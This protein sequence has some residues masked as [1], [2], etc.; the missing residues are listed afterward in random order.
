[1]KRFASLS[2]ALALAFAAPALAEERM[3]LAVGASTTLAFSEPVRRIDIDKAGVLEASLKDSEHVVVKALAPG[4]AQLSLGGGEHSELYVV[5]VDSP[6]TLDARALAE[7]LRA[8]PGLEE[9]AVEKKGDAFVLSGPVADLESHG[10]AVDLATALAGKPPVDMMQVEG[11]QMVAVDI[12]FFAV[13]SNTLRALGFNLASLNGDLQGAFTAPNTLQDFS[14]NAEGLSI[15][16]SPALQGAFNLLLANPKNGVMGIFSALSNAGLSRVLAQPTLLVRSGDQAEFLAGGDVPI[17]VPQANGGVGATVTIEYRPYGVRLAVAPVVMSDKRIVLKLTP[18]VSELDYANRIQVQGFSIPA[19]RR[20]SAS[21]TV[22]LGDGQ[23][24]VI[25]GLMY[26]SSN[27]NQSKAPGL[28]DLPIIGGLFRTSQAQEERQELVIVATPRL[29]DPL[30]AEAVEAL[31]AKEPP[32]YSPTVGQM[33]FGGDRA[34]RQAAR[35][36]LSR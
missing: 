13:S 34:E 32:P 36:G 35:F 6:P 26:A 29:V 23:S 24:F 18:E 25:A 14:L 16:A 9:A 28:G 17:P 30:D 7:R 15:K 4:Q 3:T 5:D 19:F 27:T 31:Q 8:E 11:P 1:M 21:T 33:M 2:A 12:R 22:Q 10:R 20:R